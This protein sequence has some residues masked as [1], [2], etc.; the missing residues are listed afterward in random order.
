MLINDNLYYRNPYESIV[1]TGH[2]NCKLFKKCVTSRDIKFLIFLYSTFI[3][4]KFE[5]A[6]CVWS[7]Y[8][9]KDVDLLEDVQRKFT[10]FLPGFYD[11]SYAERLSLLSMQTLEERR[12]HMDL[13]LVY[14]INHKLVDI[15]FD[16]FFE[17]NTSRT[18]GHS[19]KLSVKSS[20]VNCHKFH[21]F[22][23]VV[24][25][26]NNVPERIVTLEKLNQFKSEIFKP[27]VKHY[28]IGRAFS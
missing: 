16:K 7:P 13:I 17:F 21:F 20:R 25:V 15:P 26:W 9:K 24:K 27:N 12:I 5:Y 11:K 3:L 28:C 14:E 6:S 2:Y 22:N 18:R 1:K 4:P 23:R 8:Y 19:Y 10:K